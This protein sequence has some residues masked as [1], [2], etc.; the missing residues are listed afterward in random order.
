MKKGK[1]FILAIDP[2]LSTTGYAIIDYDTEEI[3]HLDKFTTTNK[4]SQDERI[5]AIISKLY[6]IAKEYAIS[7][8]V[9]ED[10]FCGLNA[11]TNLSLS[12][13]RG[14]IIAVFRFTEH[15]V[16]HMLPSVIRKLFGCGGNAKKEQVAE[17]VTELYTNNPILKAVGPYSDKQ[18]K[19]K[20][21]DIYDAISI[22]VSYIRLSKNGAVNG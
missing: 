5:D 19:N 21:S 22:G 13:L 14:G 9:L 2:A 4:L 11:R 7:H 1:K 16:Q 8:I 3:V 17:K 15:E 18:N 10:G 6:S 20:T 12:A